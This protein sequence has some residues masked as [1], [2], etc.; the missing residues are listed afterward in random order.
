MRIDHIIYGTSDLDA[1]EAWFESTSGLS[2]VPGGPHD[3]LGT[4]NRI[5]P[6]GDE[7]FIELVAIADRVQASRS[8]VGA[9]LREGIARGDGFLG[10][11]VAV[12][13]LQPI[14]ARLGVSRIAVTRQGMTARL[15][16][17]TESLAEP[18]L[19]FFIERT[20]HHPPRG[21]EAGA[22][23][24]IEVA[25]NAPRLAFWLGRH[26]LPVRIV[27]GDPGVRAVRVGNC[28]LRPSRRP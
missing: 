19:P 21:S 13:D 2:A 7:S 5:V 12:D 8:A 9:A 26:K 1:A 27:N 14:I 15:A 25:C 20:P 4:H 3:G 17:V 23:T 28:E 22:I 10:W 6:L 18:G 16:G 11:A 24:R